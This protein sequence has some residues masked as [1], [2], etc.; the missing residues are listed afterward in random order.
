MLAKT[1]RF[2]LRAAADMADEA[3]N[4]KLPLRAAGVERVNV[5]PALI[6]AGTRLYENGRYLDAWQLV[7]Q[8][9]PMEHWRGAEA[10]T[11]GYRLAN[12][13]GA[14]RL[15]ELLICRAR[16]EDPRHLYT[17]V[18]FGYYLQG[19][20]LMRAWRH[21]LASEPL[22]VEDAQKLSYLKGMRAVIAGTYRDF[23][24]AFP[25]LEEAEALNP[26]SP[27]LGVERASIEMN[28]ERHLKALEALDVALDIHPWYRPAVQSRGRVLHLLGRVDEAISF[29]TNSLDH[30]QSTALV[31]QLMTLKR[32]M[33]DHAGMEALADRFE[34]MAGHLGTAER[35]FVDAQRVDLLTLRGDFAR[36]AE[37]AEKLPGKHFASLARRLRAPGVQNTRKRLPTEFV[38]Q[39]HNTCAPAT[40]AAIAAWW[41]KPI[42]MEQIVDAICYDGTYDHSERTWAHENGFASREF[43]VTLE[44]ARRLIDAD[45]PFVLH[46]VEVGSGHSQAVVGY[47]LLRESL[48]IQDPGEPHYREVTA[49]EFLENYRL[50]GPRG[51]V[52]VPAGQADRLKTFDLPDADL[53]E[54]YHRLNKALAEYQREEAQNALSEL[55]RAAPQHRLTLIARV[56]LANFDGNDV[57]RLQA[58]EQLMQV[59]PDDPRVL[60]WHYSVLR[61]LGTREQRLRLLRGMTARKVCP[62]A[63]HLGLISELMDDARDWPEARAL[64]W[65][66]HR[67][68]PGASGLLTALGVVLRRVENAPADDWLTPHR[69]ATAMTDK[70][71]ANAES[72]FA[73]MRSQGRTDE[74]LAWL[75]RRVR[76]YGAKSP[77]P[78]MTLASALDSM[79]LPE[80]HDVLRAALELHPD[81]GDLLLQLLH[82]EMRLGNAAEAEKRLEQARGRCLPGQW[83]RAK[84]ALARRFAGHAAELE[85]YREI[86]A[87]EPLALDAHATYARDLAASS[88]T[89]AAV[90]HLAAVTTRFPHHNGLAQLHAHW[91]RESAPQQAVQRLHQLVAQHP[92]DAWAQRELALVLNDLGRASEALAPAEKAVELSPDLA[93]SHAVLASVLSSL[94]RSAQAHERYRT[95]IHLDVNQSG[96]MAGL[97]ELQPGTDA[98]RKELRFIQ[99]EMVRQVLTGTTLHAFRGHAFSVLSREE[100]LAELRIIHTARPDLWEAWSVL[101][102]QLSDCGQTDE[103]L[104]LAQQATQIFA[105]LP[106]AWHDMAEAW[107]RAGKPDAA[108]QCARH[109][110]TLNPD[111][112][113]GWCLLARFQDD[114]QRHEEAVETLRA[115]C[116][117]LPLE[118]APRHQLAT[119][120]HRLDR[121]EEAWSMAEK[122]VNEDP[123]VNWAW[124]ALQT[125]APAM[126]RSTQL[127][128]IAEKLTQDRPDEARSWDILSRLLPQSRITEL[129]A[130]NERALKLNPRLA[131]AWD[132]RMETLA[133]MGRL[134]EAERVPD[135]TP[136]RSEE[137]PFNLQGRHAWLTAMRGDAAGAMRRMRVVLERHRDYQWGWEMYA[138]WAEQ[139]SDVS[140]WRRAAEELIRLAPRQPGPYCTAAEAALRAGQRDRG[141]FLLRQALQ[142]DPGSP[143]AAH[144]LLDLHWQKREIAPLRQ[145]AA[146]LTNTGV[147][148][149]IKRTYLTLAAAHQ[150]ELKQARTELDWLATQ[151]DRLGPLLKTILDYFQS[152]QRKTGDMLNEAI[153]AA[154]SSDRIG[155]SFAILWVELE[156]QQKR[157]QCWQRLSTWMERL[158]DQLNPAIAHYLD[159]IGTAGAAVPH[160]E[161]FIRA[162]GPALRR[163]A[164]IWGKVGY[165]LASASAWR[166]SAEWLMPDYRREDAPAWAL[167]NLAHS[168]RMLDHHEVALEVSQHV[169]EHGVRDET[170]PDHVSAAAYGLA[171]VKKD[172]VAA[173]ALLEREPS[174]PNAAGESYLRYII[175]R[176]LVNVHTEPP[177]AAR[178]H[179]KHFLAESK[180]ILHGRAVSN[181]TANEYNEAVKDMQQ[182][183]G[184]RVWPW[185]RAKLSD[186]VTYRTSE[187]GNRWLFVFLAIMLINL[188][189]HCG[190]QERYPSIQPILDDA[191]RASELRPL[192]VPDPANA[193]TIPTLRDTPTTV[194]PQLSPA[195][196]DFLNNQTPNTIILPGATR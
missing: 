184:A 70:V 104:R 143:A 150:S 191:R 20:G 81:S 132:F 78:A 41:R 89:Q 152:N 186:Q 83:L 9:G 177:Q 170:W 139:R 128:A 45:I 159:A 97:L 182:H 117:R 35:L 160:V 10:Q 96:C 153:A 100:L 74:A 55:E 120:L 155:P 76:D 124:A 110:V 56:T 7:R 166:A 63:F 173:Q 32:E 15:G 21:C 101:I 31:M 148:G 66:A 113:A 54:H 93:L 175:A 122:V 138:L 53:Y 98:K 142:A 149:L 86:L 192:S 181:Q 14:S 123:G 65:R 179:F 190:T 144:L 107:S 165:A 183:T 28:A 169:L 118:Q 36:A 102:E 154:A 111:W 92:Q 71:E 16:R 23:G 69:L 19:Q 137:L 134:D 109:I 131:D 130:A 167:W 88:D 73:L 8:A 37:V 39:K 13:L 147:C 48:F 11:F 172:Y 58:I 30:I 188:L 135:D 4:L 196:I 67:R 193:L 178:G 60:H 17:A 68:N 119:L 82:F 187:G 44:A 141:I 1:R 77:A 18:H 91:L 95:A 105:L 51:L 180:K 145:A 2:P 49:D 87:K 133:R 176:A 195:E 62:P 108:E 163:D 42:A 50:N 40:L 125:W 85:V 80:A 26:R 34:A 103:A 127:I 29:L 5:D 106:G 79:N 164:E 38:L 72:W 115:A 3:L 46:T 126:Q 162:Q 57:A 12:N 116:A 136:W 156:V 64:V 121:R 33:D 171:A 168:Q 99:D 43:T 47:D 185:E 84:A 59:F 22:A 157:W 189:R 114:A 158:G 27:W 75:R 146:A 61:S 24:T 129:L 112:T 52:L 174:P 25:L 140:E 161:A 94:G 6:E 194:Q 151:P 90:E